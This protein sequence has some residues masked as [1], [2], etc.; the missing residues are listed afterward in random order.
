MFPPGFRVSGTI[1]P[2]RQ[3]RPFWK[4]PARQLTCFF[5]HSPLSALTRGENISSRHVSSHTL[6]HL[7]PICAFGPRLLRHRN[8]EIDRMLDQI[9]I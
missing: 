6:I 5:L 1:P 7:A 4:E 3:D 8:L 9:C 2:E